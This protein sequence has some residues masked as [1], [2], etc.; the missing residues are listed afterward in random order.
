MTDSQI[1]AHYDRNYFTWQAK[2]GLLTGELN[3]QKFQEYVPET[4]AIL[5]F[6]SGGGFLLEAL[7]AG[8]KIGVEI[9][10]VA[11]GEARR[12]GIAT[13]TDL[14]EVAD[15]SIDVVVSNHALEHVP[16]PIDIARKLRAKLRPTGLAVV[17]VPCERYD[18]A[19]HRDDIDRHLYTWSPLNLG[20]L[21]D[22]AGFEI[23]EVRRYAHRWL[24][25]IDRI[26]RIFGRR[27]TNAL[28]VLHA[29]LRPKMTQ[30]RLVARPR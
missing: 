2:Y 10:E 29:H 24:P 26:D 9:N 27:I 4:A 28:C 12:R 6:G 21:F 1:S 18:M 11:A 14:D 17:V 20:N 3:A 13:V 5:D 15:G 7:R 23:V 19:Y 22:A 30:V 8:S 25:R 16:N